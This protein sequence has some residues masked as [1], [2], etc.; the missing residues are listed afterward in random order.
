MMYSIENRMEYWYPKIPE[1]IP[2]PITKVIMINP[3][4]SEDG[5]HMEI[6][7]EEF[8][9]V[10]KSSKEFSFPLFMRGSE[11]SGKHDWMK[12]CFVEKFEDIRY[13]I[14]A[15]IKDAM[16]KD[17]GCNSIVLREFIEMDTGFYAFRNMPVNPERRYFIKNGKVLCHHPYWIKDA[18]NHPSNKNWEKILEEMNEETTGEIEILTSYA[19]R[20]SKEFEGYW[21]IDFCRTKKGKWLCIDMA[22]G[23]DSWHPDCI[24]KLTKSKYGS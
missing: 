13:H 11:T 3:N 16:L 6:S 2:K 15:L 5:S 21:S 20:I 9:E 10:E 12:T 24:H 8:Q 14:T 19:E 22:L 17:I 7:E 4:W 1:L 18:I 23:E